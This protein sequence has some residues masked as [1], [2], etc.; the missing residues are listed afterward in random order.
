[1]GFRSLAPNQKPGVD[2]VPSAPAL[3]K[4]MIRTQ[5]LTGQLKKPKQIKGLMRYPISKTKLG[6][7]EERQNHVDL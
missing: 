2:Y 6:N 3:G 5:G 7:N 1:M 4:E